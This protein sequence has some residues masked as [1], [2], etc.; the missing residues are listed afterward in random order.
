MGQVI[1][2]ENY[3]KKQ[4]RGIVRVSKMTSF[5]IKTGLVKNERQA[6]YLK[7]IVIVISFFYIFWLASPLIPYRFDGDFSKL[8][9]D[10][11]SFFK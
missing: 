7:L 2:E 6:T 5:L 11:P 1:F 10:T 3:I 4:K 9:K 8:P